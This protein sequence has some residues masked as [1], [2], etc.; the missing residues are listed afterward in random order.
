MAKKL[1][2]MT[3]LVAINNG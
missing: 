1:T 3:T 2:K